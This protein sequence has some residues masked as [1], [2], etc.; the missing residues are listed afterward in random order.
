[1]QRKAIFSH[2]NMMESRL[3]FHLEAEQIWLASSQKSY[4]TPSYT[5]NLYCFNN[6][7]TPLHVCYCHAMAMKLEK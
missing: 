7:S 1:M 5:T 2:H 6:Y 3:Y 4:C